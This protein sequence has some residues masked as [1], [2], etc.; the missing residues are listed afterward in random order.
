M[1]EHNVHFPLADEISNCILM[2]RDVH[3]GGSFPMMIDYYSKDGK[4]VQDD[5]SIEHI[6][7]LYAYEQK[8]GEDLSSKFL[9]EYDLKEIELAKSKYFTLRG[10]YDKQNQDNKIPR[11]I[12]DLI[13]S[14]EEPPIKE[15]EALLKEGKKAVEAL[16]ELATNRDFYQPLY[17]GYGF[18]PLL[19][20]R[21]LGHIGDIRAIK[22]LFEM[23]G[24]VD[25][26]AEEALIDAF[27]VMGEQA[28]DFLVKMLKSTPPTKDN[29]RAIV[30]LLSFPANSE[31][32]EACLKLLENIDITAHLTLA[33]YL[34][35]GCAGIT[36]L[37]QR[38]RFILLSH[39]EAWPSEIKNEIH[40]IIKSWI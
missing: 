4:G 35:C 17:P 21:C 36:D 37:M 13:L 10:F 7:E 9:S 19:A 28:K 23:I 39:H 6:N 14:E 33:N 27:S 29:E 31:I 16:I 11:L 26:E 8:L 3:F 18:A 38:E 40:A 15:V 32:G 24:I 22:P 2:H 1:S 25:F 20:I 30:I 34:V 12:A 5:F